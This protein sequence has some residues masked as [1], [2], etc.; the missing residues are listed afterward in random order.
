[1]L[2]GQLSL[3]LSLEFCILINEAQEHLLFPSK[4]FLDYRQYFCGLLKCFA[5]WLDLLVDDIVLVDSDAP[6]A[7]AFCRV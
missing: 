6:F 1:L 3:I 4:L 7:N 5:L 2:L